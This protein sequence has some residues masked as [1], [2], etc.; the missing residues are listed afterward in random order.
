MCIE[1]IHFD[2]LFP[3][4]NVLIKLASEIDCMLVNAAEMNCTAIIVL[5]K[6]EISATVKVNKLPLP[7]T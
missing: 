7:I 5:K 6:Q 3:L 2:A 1:L 4:Y